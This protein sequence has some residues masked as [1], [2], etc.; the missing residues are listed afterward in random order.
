MLNCTNGY[1][2]SNGKCLPCDSSC[3][4]CSS[5]DVCTSCNAPYI[6]NDKKCTFKPTITCVSNCSSCYQNSTYC[7]GCLAGY[8]LTPAKTCLNLCPTGYFG[9]QSECLRCNSTC[10]SCTSQD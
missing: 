6:L 1:Y 7:T 4:S 5:Q 8:F 3:Y 2:P 10:N 9:L